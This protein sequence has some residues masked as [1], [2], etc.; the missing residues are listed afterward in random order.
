MPSRRGFLALGAATAAASSLTF[1]KSAAA[2]YPDRPVRVYLPVAAGTGLDVDARS[3][4]EKFGEEL[5]QPVVVVNQPQAGGNVAMVE[6]AKAA[7]DGYTLIAAGLGPVVANAYLYKTLGFDAQHDFAPVSLMQ[8]LPSVLVVHPS[9]GV[10]SVAELIARAKAKPGEITYGSQGVGTFVHLAVEQFMAVTGVQLTHVPYARQS[11]FTD[12]AGGHVN[13]MISGIAPV[14]GFIQAGTV[15]PLVVSAKKR[16]GI[17]PDVPTAAEAGVA[18]FQAYAWNG[19]LAPRGTP[20]PI[21]ARLNQDIG[22]AV[23]SPAVRGR[24]EKF[25]GYPAAGSPADFVAFLDAERAKWS[26]V[27]ADAK[28]HLD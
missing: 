26:K 18:D 9:L 5:G 20:E 23:T 6:V 19:L 28:V 15:K 2:D 7:P 12:L 8:M 17:L 3:S 22:K 1:R 10:N 11:P 4:L 14:M 27:I 24:M 25:G 13:L 16:V 21:V